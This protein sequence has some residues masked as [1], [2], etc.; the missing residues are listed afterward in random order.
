MVVWNGDREFEGYG[1]E[2]PG[3]EPE[4][5][6]EGCIEKNKLKETGFMVPLYTWFRLLRICRCL[7]KLATRV[8]STVV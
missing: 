1:V 6:V 4:R 2:D 3:L 8:D 7:E 5:P